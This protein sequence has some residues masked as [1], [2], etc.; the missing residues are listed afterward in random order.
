MSYDSILWLLY[1]HTHKKT[2]PNLLEPKSQVNSQ[3][4]NID[5]LDLWSRN[6]V[7][8]AD[9]T[10][11]HTPADEQPKTIHHVSVSRP[12]PH[13]HTLPQ[14]PSAEVHIVAASNYKHNDCWLIPTAPSGTVWPPRLLGVSI[15]L[16]LG[17]LH[18]QKLQ[19]QLAKK[20]VITDA[21][22]TS[23]Q[24]NSPHNWSVEDIKS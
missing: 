22:T 19:A 8:G 17:F 18:K 14:K 24:V 23:K 12:N 5:K 10:F 7:E 11:G 20:S 2:P 13:T 21:W 1:L 3:Y 9:R 6:S 16:L 4:G 15:S